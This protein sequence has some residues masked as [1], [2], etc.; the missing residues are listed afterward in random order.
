MRLKRMATPTEWRSW[1]AW[2]PVITISYELVWL[3]TVERKVVFARIDNVKPSS[4][5]IYRRK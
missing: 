1:F 3:E 2:K 4:W 5:C